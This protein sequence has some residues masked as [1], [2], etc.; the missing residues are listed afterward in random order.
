MSKN[1][2]LGNGIN[3]HFGIDDL[4]TYNIYKRFLD[5]IERGQTLYKALFDV[6][7]DLETLNRRISYSSDY[8]IESIAQILYKYII[9]NAKK[10]L[11]PLEN[12]R[13]VEAIKTSAINAIFYKGNS[14]IN[15]AK[16]EEDTVKYIRT[17]E[18]I[19]SLNYCEVWDMDRK[20]IHLHGRYDICE[21]VEGSK[22]ILLYDKY[23]YG[24]IDSYTLALN[25]LKHKNSAI[26]FDG[27]DIVFSPL[28]DKQKVLNDRVV[29]P[30]DKCFPA[31]DLDV[32]QPVKLYEEL[33]N[34]ESL[35]IFG[36]S[37]YG[38]ER[39]IQKISQIPQVT[40]FVHQMEEKQ[41]SEWNRRLKREC[42]RDSALFV[43]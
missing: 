11:L 41:V 16:M 12:N 7:I 15:I 5:V 26:L 1:L 21:M 20:C 8:G 28:L 35:D 25:K 30:S 23:R 36:M 31:K 6:S 34:L 10:P 29:F 32:Y 13:L 37:P 2:L 38:D 4:G 3:M 14:R 19:F 17:Y 9:E 39:L 43:P 22:P 18:K 27:K 40:I 24:R 33:N 42:C